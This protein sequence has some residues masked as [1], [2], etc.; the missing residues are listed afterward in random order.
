MKTIRGFLLSVISISLAFL[1][2]ISLIS[3]SKGK[4][5]N[6]GIIVNLSVEPKTIDPSLNAQIYGVIY[7]SHVFEGLT[8]RDRNNKIVPGVAENWEISADGKTYTFFLRTNSTWSDGKPVVAE[9]FVYSWQRQVDPKVASEY[10]YQHEPVKNAMAITRG[11]MPV[12]SLGVKAIDDHTL[13]VELEAPT[14]YFLEVAA[15]P[16]FAP[17]R[18]DIIEQYGDNWTL[19][20][21]TYIGNGPYVMSERNIDENIIMVKNPNYWNADSIVAE[22]ITFVFMQNGAAAVAGIK[23]GSL[24]MAYEPPQ[25]D[26]PTLLEEGL[27]QIK[28]LIAT[29]YYPINVTNEYLKDPRVRKAL[30]L[31]IDRNYIVENVT[32]GGQKPAGGWV[33]YAVNDVDGDFRIN[34]GDFYDISKEGY[35][36]NVEMAKQLLAEAG[37]P[38]GEGFPVIEF[39]TD[40]GNHVGIFE[41]VQQMWKEHLNIDST[42]TQIDNALLG[43]TL[44][45]KNFM[46]GRLYWS[47]DY[48]D[49]M[50]MMSLFTSYNTQNNGG[51]SNKRYDELIGEAMST[52]DNNIRMKAMHEAERI[53]IEEDMGAIPLYFFTEPLLVNPKLRDVV[54]NPLGFHKFFYAYLEE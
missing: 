12:D 29:Y 52:D 45:E 49:P 28:P 17:L 26:I 1:M 6:E 39:K 40:P 54:Y 43:Q 2:I 4:D 34:G 44:L 41:A 20:P 32:K 27:I 48:S 14:A 23:D 15:F 47:A 30:S 37:Y 10:S 18:K 8:V 16:T 11:E 24:H 7:I 50:S 33:P 19:K 5:T 38:N 3:C 22:K 53:L 51:Y 13:V 31:A 42:I 21:E 36:N 9:D 46:I 25:Q 35:S